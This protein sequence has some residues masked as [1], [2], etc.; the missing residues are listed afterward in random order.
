MFD[1]I[2]CEAPL[3][4]PRHQSVSFQTKDLD[5]L[6]WTYTI[7]RTGHLVREPGTGLLG[8]GKSRRVVVPMHGDLRMY[9]SIEAKSGRR[10]WIEYRV[11]FTSGRVEWIRREPHGNGKARRLK[12]AAAA[13]RG[14]LVPRLGPRRI[15]AAELARHA[16]KRL[17]LSKG[18]IVG[19]ER[20]LLLVLS[21]LGLRHAIE[22]LGPATWQDALWSVRWP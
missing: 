18:R 7:S 3:I 2:R 1:T 21:G 8:L 4:A 14:A 13:T 15:T 5:C 11:R 9:T 22:L 20:L 10:T 6:L 16:P 17:E 19:D 12:P